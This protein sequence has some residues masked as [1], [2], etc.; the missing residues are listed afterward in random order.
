MTQRRSRLRRRFGALLFA[1]AVNLAGA[2][3]A[4]AEQAGDID[5]GL[6]PAVLLVLGL[7]YAL[8]ETVGV[9]RL[10]R[11]RSPREGWTTGA[12]AA[13]RLARV[14]LVFAVGVAF[15]WRLLWP[16]NWPAVAITLLW[17]AT[18][19]LLTFAIERVRPRPWAAVPA[20]LVADA[21]LVL[22]LNQ[23]TRGFHFYPAIGPLLACAVALHVGVLARAELLRAIRSRAVLG[24]GFFL[25]A[26]MFGNVLRQSTPGQLEALERPGIAMRFADVSVPLK[27]V[28]VDPLTGYVFYVDRADPTKIH[29]VSSDGTRRVVF[30]DRRERFIRLSAGHKPGR[31]LAVSEA[32]KGRSAFLLQLP[33]LDVQANYASGELQPGLMLGPATFY[34]TL[35]QG[36]YSGSARDEGGAFVVHCRAPLGGVEPISSMGVGCARFPLPF[37]VPGPVVSDRL[38]ERVFALEPAGPTRWSSRLAALTVINGQIVH[39]V[40]L[41]S[42]AVDM[43]LSTSRDDLYIGLVLRRKIAY[44]KADDLTARAYAP[45]HIHPTR[46]IV[47]PDGKLMYVGSFIDGQVQLLNLTNGLVARPFR[48]GPALRDLSLDPDRQYLYAATD[49]GLIRADLSL[50]VKP[51][52][53]GRVPTTSPNAVV[54]KNVGE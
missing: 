41:E 6:F 47:D 51:T 19:A 32:P 53:A 11:G 1:V 7:L 23:A 12:E 2:S 24:L 33:E 39:D 13:I 45:I 40:A 31:M 9:A 20:L 8:F 26:L 5:L 15:M 4:L 22:V 34:A 21:G 38:G 43:A 37:D 16:L 10:L 25:F 27:A 18:A 28:Y 30:Q 3:T 49:V 46:L 14:V 17:Y 54:E 42:P 35:N 29:G 52:G 36:E 44:L 50:A 48:M